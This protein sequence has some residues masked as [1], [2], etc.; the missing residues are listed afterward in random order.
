MLTVRVPSQGVSLDIEVDDPPLT[1]GRDPSGGV[2]FTNPLVSARHARV[3][4]HAGQWVFEDVGSTNGSFVDG[5]Q[6][7]AFSIDAS[8][9]V[10]LGD[11]AV[12]ELVQLEVQRSR[13][14]VL[15]ASQPGAVLETTT[16]SR[17]GRRPPV[18]AVHDLTVETNGFRRLDRLSLALPSGVMLGVLGGS[19]AGKS[20]LVKAITGA[21]PATSGLVVFEGYDLYRDY[22]QVRRRIGYVPQDDILHTTLTVR[23][24]LL[25]GTLLRMPEASPVERAAR[26]TEVLDELGLSHR[27]DALVSELSGGQRKRLN[28]ALELLARPP[29]L[30]LDEPTSGLDP[31]NERSLMQLLR[32]LAD[33][34]RTV[35][36]VTHSTE[37]LHLCDDVLVLARGGVP[38][39]LGPAAGFAP[40][41]GHDNLI[42]AF[43][44]VDEHPDPSALRAA[45]DA[46]HGQPTP[47]E[48][49]ERAPDRVDAGWQQ[50]LASAGARIG[51]EV[52]TLTRRAVD[53]LQG[54][55]R[56]ALILAAQ[57]PVIGML[58]VLLFNGGVLDT[59]PPTDPAGSSLIMA[60][61]LALV[62]VGAAGSVREIVKERP[63]MLR[64]QAVGVS[65]VAY[66]GSKLLVQGTIVVLQA[67]F[68]VVL[69]G[70]VNSGPDS[71]LL[72]LGPANELLLVVALAGLAASATG[73]LISAVVTTNDKAMTLLPVFLFVQLLL[74]G[75]IVPVHQIPMR[76]LSWIVVSKWGLDGA[77]SVGNLYLLNDKCTIDPDECSENWLHEPHNLV[78]AVVM[79][80][81][82]LAAATFATYRALVRT[83]P[84]DVLAGRRSH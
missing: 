58:L 42:D 65:T 23:A 82:L 51:P 75:L 27:V 77:G 8:L 34:D 9:A 33:G 3:Y 5:V 19:G 47:P 71:G 4:H 63:I 81:L 76:F 67:V 61:V 62:F 6:Q 56:N 43:G 68:I 60:I 45:F 21:D 2:V 79:L 57:A 29:L 28:V 41:F 69:A 7:G 38:A 74:A 11:P 36:V 48:V 64:E 14:P 52:W 35:I 12:G 66:L 53:I 18:F 24:T 16:S 40:E 32:Q 59:Q 55:R 54:D 46:R 84:A 73:L 20:T 15:L 50:R 10:M 83:D 17:P 80:T 70:V 44:T 49:T 1:V 13:P 72:G 26:A 30:I 25:Y 39:Y 78:L 31:A 22:E 37:S